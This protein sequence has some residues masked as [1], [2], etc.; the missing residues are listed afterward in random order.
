MLQPGPKAIRYLFYLAIIGWLI[1]T[2]I[3][4]LSIAHIDVAGYIPFVWLL[5]IGIFIIWF[6]IIFFLRNNQSELK[7]LQ[8]TQEEVE[9]SR[10]F[11]KGILGHCPLWLRLFVMIIAVYMGINFLF[12]SSTSGLPHFENGEYILQAR[13]GRVIRIITEQEYHYYK[14]MQLRRFSGHW[15]FF[16]GTAIA[17]LFPVRKKNLDF[18]FNNK[19]NTY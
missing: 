18:H 8:A 7:R 12:L 16:Y 10:F 1:G 15:I 2:T 13:G 3:H 6:S 4:I 19:S 9:R 14:A 11:S 17:I 5:H